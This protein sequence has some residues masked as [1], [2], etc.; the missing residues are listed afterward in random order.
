MNIGSLNVR[1]LRAKVDRL[2]I[3]QFLKKERIDIACLQETH[4]VEDE[5]ENTT[6]G[7]EWGDSKK[8]FFN[9]HTS[10][11]RGTAILI[12]ENCNIKILK[13]LGCLDGRV[14][15]LIIE[16]SFEKGKLLL[17]NLYAPS[18][19]SQERVEFYQN[20]EIEMKNFVKNENLEGSLI[21][22]DFNVALEEMDRNRN[23]NPSE[24]PSR[25]L[26]KNLINKYSLVD[27]WRKMNPNLRRYSWRAPNK[28]QNSAQKA[29]R[30]DMCLISETLVGNLSASKLVTCVESDHSLVKTT[31]KNIDNIER[32]RGTYKLNNNLLKDKKF[33]NRVTYFWMKHQ[34]T[35]KSY[36]NLISW[37]EDGK[38]NIAELAKAYSLAKKKQENLVQKLLENKLEKATKNFDINPNEHTALEFQNISKRL[39]DLKE[40]KIK[41]QIIRSKVQYLEE[42]EKSSRYF[43]QLEKTRGKSKLF[44]RVENEEGKIV[45]SIEDIL[46]AQVKFYEK[47]Y[48][49]G[50][51]SENDQEFFIDK[52]EKKLSIEDKDELDRPF[53]IEELTKVVQELQNNKSPGSDS[54]TSEFYKKFWP[55]LK[56]DFLE[57]TEEIKRTGKMSKSQRLAI[58]TLLYKDG[59]KEKLKNWRPI[60]LLNT[61]Y[62]IITKVLANR[63][64]K[65]LDKIIH[66]DQTCGIKNR[67]IFENIIFT[68]D[69]IFFSN[70]HNKPL[71]IVSVDQ[72]KAFD[73]VNRKF[74]LKILEKFGFGK[75]F[76]DWIKII[77][78]DT[79][80]VICTNGHISKTFDLTRGVRQGCPLSPLLY[81]IVAE[82]I[83]NTIRLDKNIVGFK[84]P[85]SLET[86]LK[87]YAD[88]TLI[89]LSDIKSITALFRL[90]EK[91]G[92]ASEAKLNVDKSKLMLTGSLRNVAIPNCELKK[93]K[94]LKILGVW[95]GDG[96]TD[97][98][99]DNWDKVID[100][101]TNTLNVWKARDISIFGRVLLV[102]AL[103]LS[104]LWYILRVEIPDKDVIIS[105][106]KEVRDFIWFKKKQLV[107]DEKCKLKISEGGLGLFDISSKSKTMRVQWL[108]SIYGQNKQELKDWEIMGRFFVDNCNMSIGN[109]RVS[110]IDMNLRQ[111]KNTHKMSPEFY[112]D[113]IETWRSLKF[114][115]KSPV[116]KS[117]VFDEYLWAN[118]LINHEYINVKWILGGIFCIKDIWSETNKDWISIEQLRV[119]LGISNKQ[120]GLDKT[121]RLDFENLKKSIPIRWQELMRTNDQYQNTEI[122]LDDLFII[123]HKH[124]NSKSLYDKHMSAS[125]SN[126]NLSPS[127]M[128][129]ASDIAVEL[130]KPFLDQLKNND[131]NNK[132]KELLWKIFNRGLPLGYLTKNWFEGETGFCKLCDKNELETFEHLFNFCETTIKLKR[133]VSSLLD[134]EDLSDIN[135]GTYLNSIQ[136]EENHSLFILRALLKKTLWNHRNAIIFKEKTFSFIGIKSEFINLLK[137][138][139]NLI[140]KKYEEKGQVNE[141]KTKYK[142]FY[143]ENT[144]IVLSQKGEC[145]IE[146]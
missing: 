89:F 1:G 108:W 139:I 85:S 69:A 94:K 23:R 135:V 65:K 114:D 127:W 11:T 39:K 140:F 144:K 70:K 96:Y 98:K 15:L 38:N 82:S 10:K 146:L 66:P 52:I 57:L 145:R 105:I 75:N 93:E 30:L 78:N 61:D 131:I 121:L 115:R 86:K 40:E 9:S 120:Y 71:A 17:V 79:I 109:V 101:I 31:F 56:N 64:K 123:E 134:T 22:G 106:E 73:R 63:L 2:Q 16:D 76:V 21:L 124:L 81:I 35:K 74:M 67:T 83:A 90:L 102:N 125:Q 88:D 12:R 46:D 138:T 132:V 119:K 113:I 87:C 19:G 129:G 42:G 54:L 133:V 18:D 5:E 50:E 104:K 92:K 51:T 143:S 91:F 136:R 72:S 3:Y 141:F 77:Y 32:G 128:E 100:K 118:P 13:Y 130:R 84:G 14:Q 95:V 6:W 99:S 27:S 4:S 62:K 97:V 142:N 116:N 80:S 37:W 117:Q 53:E 45:N 110:C 29:A 24:D 55:I 41:G 122:S 7:K 36:N 103:A 68:K 43:F 25:N 8:C 44:D 26:L 111:S 112:Y 60:S 33:C 137:N 58:L 59:E 126:K 49:E 47:L 48:Q 107:S 34:K 20:F 28:R